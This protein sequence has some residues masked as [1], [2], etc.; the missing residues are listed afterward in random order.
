M[1]QLVSPR[2]ST[3]LD[4]LMSDFA[5]FTSGRTVHSLKMTSERASSAEERACR[6]SICTKGRQR[7]A[8]Y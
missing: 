8:P 2:P 4:T 7:M 3:A 1:T 5:C 6:R